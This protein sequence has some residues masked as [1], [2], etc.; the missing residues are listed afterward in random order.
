MENTTLRNIQM[1]WASDFKD[2]A[3]FS[4][5]TWTQHHRIPNCWYSALTVSLKRR[6]L[7]KNGMKR[8]G[9]FRWNLVKHDLNC[10]IF[11]SCTGGTVFDI[12]ISKSPSMFFCKNLQTT[13]L[14]L[15]AGVTHG[16]RTGMFFL[17][18]LRQFEAHL[19]CIE[20]VL[21]NLCLK[22]GH[23]CQENGTNSLQVFLS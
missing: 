7:N 6:G 22:G 11:S 16:Q 23:C 2:S 10:A 1:C 13:L 5:C 9:A 21:W 15:H 18:K 12:R 4:C 17:V 8:E 3:S 19:F 14:Q 20:C